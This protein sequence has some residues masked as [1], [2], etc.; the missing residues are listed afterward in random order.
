MK[1]Q[2]LS[3]ASKVPAAS[4]KYYLRAGLLHRGEKKNATTAVYDETHLARLELIQGLRRIIDAPIEH[5][6]RLTSL[7]DDPG[8]PTI[9]I[10]REAHHL[11]AGFGPGEGTTVPSPQVRAHVD[12]LM[13]ERGWAD[14]PSSSRHTLEVVLQEMSDHGYTP[15]PGYLRDIAA[16]LDALSTIDLDWTTMPDDI[17]DRRPGWRD[18]LALRVAVGEHQHSRLVLALLRLGHTSH[19][20]ERF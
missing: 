5:I 2:H 4:I 17:T 8:T 3:A 19:S 6:A 1:L 12:E 14:V 13:R 7:L 9:H 15:A 18:R 11:G 20:I 10:L 16:A